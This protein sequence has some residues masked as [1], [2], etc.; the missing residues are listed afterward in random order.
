VC[1]VLVLALPVGVLVVSVWVAGWQ[2]RPILTESMAPG[3]P[4][5]SLLVVA[6][7]SAAG[8]EVGMVVMFEDPGAPGRLVVHRVVARTGAGSPTFRTRGD[9]NNASDPHPVPASAIR[10]EVRW[11]VPALGR[12]LASLSN[13]Q[14]PWLLFAA[15]ASALALSELG[16]GRSRRRPRHVRA[17]LCPTCQA[18]L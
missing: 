15:P 12:A 18:E 4:S 6:P 16:W 2:L 17:Q 14:A 9:A 10:G 8:V 11:A 7:P 3:Y 5:G 13:P 1:A